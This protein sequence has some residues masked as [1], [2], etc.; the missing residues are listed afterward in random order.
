MI[1]DMR[2]F[3]GE[4]FDGA[5]QNISEALHSMDVLGIEMASGLPVQ[6][7]FLQSG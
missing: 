7:S 4:S 2:I 6:T 3:L 1:F 5:R